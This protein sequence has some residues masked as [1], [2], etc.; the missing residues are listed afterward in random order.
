V[1]ALLWSGSAVT[2]A[3]TSSTWGSASRGAAFGDFAVFLLAAGHGHG[4]GV[5]V[6]VPA[7]RDE[8]AAFAVADTLAMHGQAAGQPSGMG[9]QESGER[10]HGRRGR[11]L[12]AVL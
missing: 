12:P 7:Q 4:D 8:Q 2:S 9:L 10:A 5:S 3:S 1:S 6:L 11:S